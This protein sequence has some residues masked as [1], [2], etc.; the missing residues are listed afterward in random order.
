MI[1]K[2]DSDSFSEIVV[3]D[4]VSLRALRQELQDLR[5]TPD[6]VRPTNAELIDWAQTQ[7]P[8]FIMKQVKKNRID[9]LV[10]KID[11]LTAL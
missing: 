11:Q 4:T 3:Q 7:H 10:S 8:F 1:I 5:N 9:E 2:N 6:P